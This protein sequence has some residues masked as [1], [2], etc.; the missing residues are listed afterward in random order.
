MS[1]NPGV[2]ILALVTFGMFSI[3]FGDNKFFRI[4]EHIYVGVTAGN[5]VVGGWV[6]LRNSGINPV[7]Q[8]DV[9]MIIP[10]ALGVLL[11]TRFSMKNAWMARYPVGWFVGV[12]LGVSLVTTLN[13]QLIGQVVASFKPLTS[14]NI[15]LIFAGVVGTI[16]Y[17]HFSMKQTALVRS[18]AQF[19]RWTMMIAFGAAFGN[20]VQSRISL[21]VSRFMDILGVWLGII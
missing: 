9:K 17:F 4:V 19:G 8:G 18:I 20:T 14:I 6:Y 21:L 15:L 1:T 16:V 13:V 11:F 12:G 5:A 7:L 2:W 10:I 3:L